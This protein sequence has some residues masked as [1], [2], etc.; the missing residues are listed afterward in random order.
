[1]RLVMLSI[2]PNLF[3]IRIVKKRIYVFIILVD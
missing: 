3:I 1:M 2:L